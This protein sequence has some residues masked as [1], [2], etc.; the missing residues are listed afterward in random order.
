MLADNLIAEFG[1]EGVDLLNGRA[2]ALPLESARV[3]R[4]DAVETE[5]ALVIIAMNDGLALDAV[6][7]LLLDDGRTIAR[8]ALLDDR[9]TIAIPIVVPVALA[10][11][12]AG[13][14][15]ADANA[16]LIRHGR[17]RESANRRGNQQNFVFLPMEWKT[18]G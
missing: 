9:G 3:F 11:A 17:P 13:A 12:D 8:L 5:K 18:N 10:D 16:D 15:R 2:R 1:G 14:D 4:F 6:T 7:M